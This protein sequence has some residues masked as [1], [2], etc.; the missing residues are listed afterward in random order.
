MVAVV[1]PI[2]LRS[3]PR[4]ISTAFDKMM[5]GR[6]DLRV[7]TEPFSVPY[8]FGPDRSSERFDADRHPG[9]TYGQVWHDVL[10]AAEAEPVFVKAMAHHVGPELGAERLGRCTNSFLIRD[11][12]RAVPSFEARWPDVTE[13]TAARIE[14]CRVHYDALHAH[15]IRL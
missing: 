11:P 13:H 1:P 12:A 6:G 14:Q 8:Y 10:G 15:R 5:R 2:V 7:F 4:S 3:T 9:A